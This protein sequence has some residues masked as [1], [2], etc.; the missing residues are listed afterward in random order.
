LAVSTDVDEVRL[1]VTLRDANYSS[2]R[3]LLRIVGGAEI[4]RRDAITRNAATEST[5]TIVLPAAQVPAADYILTIQGRLTTGGFEDLNQTIL[6][7]T[8]P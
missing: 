5:F 7:V 3:A 6:R 2:Y 1:D 8:R 4:A